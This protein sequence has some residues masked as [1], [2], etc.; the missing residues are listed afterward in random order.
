[1]FCRL[2]DTFRNTGSNG[3]HENVEL[4]CDGVIMDMDYNPGRSVIGIV[5]I[6]K[7]KKNKSETY[8]NIL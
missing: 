6:R 4:A 3:L 1:L 5:I 2:H 7:H 8:Q